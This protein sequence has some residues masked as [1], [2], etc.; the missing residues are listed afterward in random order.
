MS[1][2]AGGGR[3]DTGGAG[4]VS[5]GTGAGEA[6]DG[7]APARNAAAASVNRSRRRGRLWGEEE[8][9][10]PCTDMTASAMASTMEDRVDTTTTSPTQ[11]STRRR[12]GAVTEEHAEVTRAG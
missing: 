8:R 12:T 10:T 2:Q 6:A 3:V 5:S 11:R 4:A 1:W 9:R 7:C